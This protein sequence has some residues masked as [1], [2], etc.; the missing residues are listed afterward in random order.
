ME[1]LYEQL[2][3]RETLILAFVIVI[4][5]FFV[6]R[7]VETA[8]P[9]CKGKK[10]G[11]YK[12]KFGL[13][14]NSVILYAIPVVLGIGV[15]IWAFSASVLPGD[16]KTTAGAGM[17]GAIVGWCSSFGYKV[18]RKFLKS[19]TGVDLIPGPTDPTKDSEEP[20][21]KDDDDDD[22]EEEAPKS[23]KKDDDKE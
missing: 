9:S 16:F 12:T 13:W 23:D 1:Q 2:V 18:V 8:V 17:W 10:D 7:I 4:A 11:A 21:A 20:L 3:R 22:D 5:T 6:R 19:K 15:A 14:W